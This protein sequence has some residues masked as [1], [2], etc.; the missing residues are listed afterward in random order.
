[1]E[2]I[3]EEL[4]EWFMNCY[5][6]FGRFGIFPPAELGGSVLIAREE[7]LTPEENVLQQSSKE[8]NEK[9]VNTKKGS[10]EY[11]DDKKEKQNEQKL[12]SQMPVG[13]IA[14]SGLQALNEEFIRD[15][16]WRV[17]SPTSWKSEYLDLI[18]D[19]LCYELQLEMRR[20]VDELMRLEL[21][22]W[23]RALENDLGEKSRGI[24]VEFSL[25]FHKI[26]TTLYGR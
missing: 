16:S 11:Q 2:D 15:W 7:S 26:H 1:M 8:K 25:D 23:N 9:T 22:R 4:R 3:T 14:F 24:W 17:D 6:Q 5:N 10:E 13:S 12:G 18:K 20:I 19:K 21:E